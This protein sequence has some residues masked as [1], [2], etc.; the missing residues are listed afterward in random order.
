MPQLLPIAP[1]NLFTPRPLRVWLVIGLFVVYLIVSYCIFFEAIAPVADF[2]FRPAIAADSSAYW[3][4]SGVRTINFSDEEHKV[5]TDASSNLFG[6][7]LEAEIL[8][9]DFNVAVFNC[10]LF[11]FCLSILRGMPEFDRATFLLLM[12]INPYLL[13]SMITLNKEIFALAG[14]VVFIRYTDAKRFRIGWLALALM[15]SLF[16]RWQQVLVLLIYVAYE[17]KISPLRHHRRWGVAVTL[18][19]FTVLYGIV[20]HFASFLIFSE[21]AQAK[22]GHTILILDNIQANFGFPLVVIPKI[23]MNSMGQFISPGYF[24]HS[25]AS[26][27][28]TNWRDQIFA[29]MHTLFLTF[30]LLGM[31]FGRKLRLKHAPVYLLALY[32]LMTAVNPMVQPRYEYAAYVLLCL[33]ASRYFRLGLD[34]EAAPALSPNDALSPSLS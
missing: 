14:I 25:Y 8:R 33:E 28:F 34:S 1:P 3:I 13:A 26:Q 12:M 32:L 29:Q 24:L 10:L 16:A 5:G 23:L 4:A 9:T 22:A 18:L 19:G 21:L 30:L 17:S 15:L 7:V 2:N 20:F 6:P 11:I 27:D 31:F